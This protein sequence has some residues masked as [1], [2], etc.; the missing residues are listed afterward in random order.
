[1]RKIK[2]LSRRQFLK[3]CG[4]MAALAGLSD[5]YIPQIARALEKAAEGKAP[6]IWL[7]GAGCTGCT[8]SLANSDYPTVGEVVLDV[9][10]LRYSETLMAA[11]GHVAEEALKHDLEAL[12]GNYIFV[13]E[14]AIPTAEDGIYC[15]VGGK[16]FV[17]IV[18]EAAAGAKY[19]VAVGACACWG[20]IP[21]ADPNPT[22]AKGLQEVI[23]GT[24]VNIPGCPPHPDWMVGTIVNV[25]LFGVPELDELGRPKLYFGQKIHDNCP[26]RTAYESGLFVEKWAADEPEML[27][28][29]AKV[30]CKG[31]ATASDCPVRQWNSGVNWCVKAGAPCAGC[32]DPKFYNDFSPLYEPL[33]TVILEE[34]PRA[35]GF[36]T[37]GATL[38]GVGAA[39]AGGIGGYLLGTKKEKKE[40]EKK[41]ERKEGEK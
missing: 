21:S 22:G 4:T 40:G 9:I 17:E 16:P 28:C 20:G 35:E 2:G 23:G 27:Y 10:S 11:S 15:Q 34:E 36:S 13:L 18:K 30:G 25:L 19:N 26:R 6:V 33:P 37:G 3:I 8:V 38:L 12:K 31:Q 5:A 14:G 39:A 1:M 29:L 7:N 41:T 24:V 32:T